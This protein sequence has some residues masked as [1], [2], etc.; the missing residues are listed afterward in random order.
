[1]VKYLKA[2]DAVNEA[3]TK[4]GVEDQAKFYVLEKGLK[5]SRHLSDNGLKYHSQQR[6]LG[7]YGKL[8]DESEVLRYISQY[9]KIM[10]LIILPKLLC[11]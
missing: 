4:E 3:L 7:M 10:A 6:A 1:M 2:Y 9:A 5:S 11:S 8:Q